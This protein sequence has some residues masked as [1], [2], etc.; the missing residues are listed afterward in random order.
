MEEI[1]LKIAN[2]KGFNTW[3]MMVKC[4]CTT[5]PGRNVLNKSI[6][7]ALN[8]AVVSRSVGNDTKPILMTITKEQEK[9][10]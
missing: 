9:K 10:D 7:E 6:N 1:K 2:D 8:L 4:F 5:E 3:E